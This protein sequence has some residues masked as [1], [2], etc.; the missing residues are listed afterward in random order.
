MGHEIGH[1]GIGR[2]GE[3]LLWCAALHDAPALHNGDAVANF[4]SLVQ[5]VADKD[6][7][8][9]QF[10]LQ[11]QQFVLQA[12]ADQRI[13]RGKRLVHQQNWGVRGKGPGQA[14]ALLHAAR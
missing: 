10:G 5:I 14:H 2:G 9:F 12:G 7:G 6:D 11:V 8:A 1:I 13:E 3:N 4:E